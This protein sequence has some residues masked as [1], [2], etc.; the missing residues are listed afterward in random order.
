MVEE[1]CIIV[2]EG[3]LA[4]V[5]LSRTRPLPRTSALP[6]GPGGSLQTQTLQ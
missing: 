4:F 1:E 5:R 3:V 2:P 6:G